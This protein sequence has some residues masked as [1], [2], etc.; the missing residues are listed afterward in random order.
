MKASSILASLFFG[1]L[2]LAAPVDRRAL[3][4]KT[5]TV[6]ETQIIFV[7]V[8]EDQVPT[9]APTFTPGLFYEERP[10]SEPAITSTKEKSSSASPMPTPTPA[11]VYTPETPKE[12]PAY[13]P[14]P[15]PSPEPQPEPQPEPEPEPEQPAPQPAPEQ[16]KYVPADPAPAPPANPPTNGGNMRQGKMTVYDTHNADGACG[17]KLSDVGYTAAIP[18]SQWGDDI[19]GSP[20]NINGN[21]WCGQKIKITYNGKTIDATVQ[22]KCPG[23]DPNQVDVTRAAWNDVT[24]NEPQGKVDVS[25]TM[26]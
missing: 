20:D 21:A 26:A 24:N 2:A 6:L 13:T 5:E 18:A 12:Q 7:T 3:V 4:T 8:W 16:P 11:P 23:C 14:A 22:D 15:E 1:S 19:W 25:W 17:R 10:K 9:A